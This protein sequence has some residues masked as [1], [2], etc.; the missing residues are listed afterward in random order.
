MNAYNQ[1]TFNVGEV[2]VSIEIDANGEIV[3]VSAINAQGH[4]CDLGFAIIPRPEGDD[5]EFCEWIGRK[6][7]CHA[8][9]CDM[10]ENL[11][12]KPGD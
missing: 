10:F 11:T 6:Y 9:P 1:V 7:I 8:V 5:C 4:A 12:S 3:G 2:N